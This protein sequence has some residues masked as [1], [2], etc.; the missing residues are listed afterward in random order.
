MSTE[1]SNDQLNSLPELTAEVFDGEK[2]PLNPVP[3]H[4]CETH[5][6]DKW[7]EHTGYVDNHD[8]TI[9]CKFCPWGAPLPGYMRLKDEKV[10]DLRFLNGSR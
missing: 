9:S 6:K 8:G 5:T 1:T 7:A 2:I 3:L 10:V 4:I